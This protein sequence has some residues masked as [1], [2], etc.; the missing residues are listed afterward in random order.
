M[1]R[2]SGVGNWLSRWMGQLSEVNA[3]IFS[4][5]EYLEQPRTII[6]TCLYQNPWEDV[7]TAFILNNGCSCV[8]LHGYGLHHPDLHYYM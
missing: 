6:N 7:F 5:L 3:G 2:G 4:H 1:E 8:G